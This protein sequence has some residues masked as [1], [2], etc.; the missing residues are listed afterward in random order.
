[1]L[2]DI[3]PRF[4][5]VLNLFH[6]RALWEHTSGR[7]RDEEQSRRQA[8][9]S[10]KKRPRAP[11]CQGSRWHWEEEGVKVTWA[12]RPQFAR[13]SLGKSDQFSHSWMPSVGWP[14]PVISLL[15]TPCQPE[16]GLLQVYLAV[17]FWEHLMVFLV[18]TG[19]QKRP[20]GLCFSFVWALGT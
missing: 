2:S 11:C 16:G 15:R 12:A 10:Q 17:K 14:G 18:T 6:L 7:E 5:G 8:T 4:A 20:E 3:Q 9:L 1:M 13:A 19:A